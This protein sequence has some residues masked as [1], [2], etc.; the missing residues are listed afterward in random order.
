[1]SDWSSISRRRFILVS[2]SL[3]AA[4]SAAFAGGCAGRFQ[5]PLALTPEERTLVEAVADQIVP[6]DQDPGGKAAGVAN[7]I[8]IQLRGPYARFAAAY[9][10][11]LARLDETSRQLRQHSFVR[12]PFDDQTAV[13][14]ALER[15]EVP[16]GIWTPRQASGFF[17]LICD[18]CMQGYYGSPR[19]GGN[20]GAASWKMLRLDYPQLAGRVITPPLPAVR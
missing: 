17:R 18:H 4:A 11:G 20:R 5:P 6:P 3:A 19:H 2:S 9:R 1:M 10:D 14:T 15:D 16:P 12:L 7:F 8:D 13:L